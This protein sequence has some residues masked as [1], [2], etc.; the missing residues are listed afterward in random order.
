MRRRIAIFV[1]IL[2]VLGAA[3]SSSRDTLPG[4]NRADDSAFALMAQSVPSATQLPCLKELPVGWIVSGMQIRDGRTQLWLD[5]TIAGV[6]AVEVDMRAT[7][8]VG[9]AVPVPPAPDEL[10]MRSFVQPDLPPGFSGVRYLLF[11][12]GCVAYRYRFTGDAP[13]TLALEAEEALSFLP[14]QTVVSGVESEYGQIM[15]GAG[16]PP[17]EG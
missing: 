2:A 17:C 11:E 6:H 15:C 16:A 7:C 4:C 3:C 12:G 13:P 9:E 14:R 8:D 5:S 10:G 1:A